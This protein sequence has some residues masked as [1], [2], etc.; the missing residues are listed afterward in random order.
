MHARMAALLFGIFFS[1]GIKAQT[2]LYPGPSNPYFLDFLL[3][4]RVEPLFAS[5]EESLNRRL[6]NTYY[7]DFVIP[8]FNEMQ[9]EEM[10]KDWIDGK[11]RSWGSQLQEK[12][13]S[14]GIS[15]E[16]L[17]KHFSDPQKIGPHGMAVLSSLLGLQVL[18]KLRF[19]RTQRDAEVY[20]YFRSSIESKPQLVA[21]LMEI[22]PFYLS[23]RLDDLEIWL[24][25]EA[26][27]S[28]WPTFL[29]S[30]LGDI[31]KLSYEELAQLVVLSQSVTQ[32]SFWGGAAE[33]MEV[34]RALR[35]LGSLGEISE[36]RLKQ[37]AQNSWLAVEEEYRKQA[38]AEWK[39]GLLNPFNPDASLT[40]SP[41]LLASG[42]ALAYLTRW[43]TTPVIPF[44]RW[45]TAPA[46]LPQPNGH[47]YHQMELASG[48]PRENLEK[49][50]KDPSRSTFP[51]DLR[52]SYPE[53]FRNAAFREAFRGA[54]SLYLQEQ[55]L[56]ELGRKTLGENGGTR[57]QRFLDNGLRGVWDRMER[58]QICAH[59]L[60]LVEKGEMSATAARRMLQSRLADH[61][62]S[63][64]LDITSRRK[65]VR[66]FLE[67]VG[68]R[69]SWWTYFPIR[70][71]K[72]LIPVQ[73]NPLRQLE[74][75]LIKF[76]PYARSPRFQG[77]L[78]IPP[79][80]SFDA[81]W[82]LEYS[83]TSIT[84]VL[85]R[86]FGSAALISAGFSFIGDGLLFAEHV[87]MEDY[88]VNQINP[89]EDRILS[90]ILKELASDLEIQALS[91]QDLYKDLKALELQLNAK[92][93]ER[94]LSRAAIQIF[95]DP[96]SAFPPE[97]T[98]AR[99][100]SVYA[101]VL[102]EGADRN[103][104]DQALLLG[105]DSEWI[106]GSSSRAEELKSAAWK[107]RLILD[108]SMMSEQSR[109]NYRS[110]L[111]R[112]PYSGYW[113]DPRMASSFEWLEPEA[114]LYRA[115]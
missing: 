18:E 83:P 14:K 78:N 66:E 74:K 46:P 103:D 97:K 15:A 100:P 107:L 9:P 79:G 99:V 47:Y 105:F 4:D 45:M 22:D 101:I 90:G 93:R 13:S 6:A 37:I 84:S 65:R 23:E 110:A 52:K 21:A 80:S 39:E 36:E 28:A 42:L 34:I 1:F 82:P 113:I 25:D 5:S 64:S 62:A 56:M 71:R 87:L 26:N 35:A 8:F 61:R 92:R 91:I 17:S 41:A 106:P 112:D 27:R 109:L 115:E 98:N 19:A 69:N 33:K 67:E 102:P 48:L 111:G 104:L 29:K 43:M 114:V 72:A 58:T 7:H 50:V 89:E 30:S 49:W 88:D 31:S 53:L 86:R 38:E 73:R 108:V 75:G 55:A 51:R 70:F 10:R 59:E 12:L 76:S 94:G 96:R 95:L 54:R 3:P 40:R 2:A 11:I 85:A 77:R 32:P 44:S 16:N 60:R 81:A 20:L 57:I 24:E 68:V 63:L